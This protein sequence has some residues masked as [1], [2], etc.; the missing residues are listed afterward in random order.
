MFRS[1]P[2]I[3]ALA[4]FLL[5]TDAF[6]QIV[7]PGAAAAQ[8]TFMTRHAVASGGRASGGRAENCRGTRRFAALAAQRR[9]HHGP[10]SELAE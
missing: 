5:G 6:A 9:G 2:L 1:P 4:A 8:A 3:A 7:P 10:A